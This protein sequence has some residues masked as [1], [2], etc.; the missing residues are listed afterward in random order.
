[1]SQSSNGAIVFDLDGTLVD[2]APDLRAALNA[3]L[4]EEGASPVTLAETRGFIGHGIPNLI[5][6]ARE[7][8]QIDPS[9]QPAMTEAMFR[10]YQRAP[11]DLTRPYS[12]AVSTLERLREAGFSLGLCTNKAT[13]PTLEILHQLDLAR[14]FQ[15]VICGDSMPQKK[16]DPTP[17]Q[18]AFAPLG[19][20]TLYVGDSEVDAECARRAKVPFALFTQGYRQ[21][22]VAEL[23]PYF[24]FDDYKEFLAVAGFQKAL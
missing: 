14:L 18:A 2:S 6:A 23:S 3:V 17:L 1:M 8:R 24:A 15:I 13:A 16:P 21:A 22:S 10:H 4:A 11:A 19:A 7:A 5:R 9:R 12:G 20:P